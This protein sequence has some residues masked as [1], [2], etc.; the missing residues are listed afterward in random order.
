MVAG[1]R[2]F[3]LVVGLNDSEWETLKSTHYDENVL[4]IMFPCYQQNFKSE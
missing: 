3:W 4:K 2:K 1:N